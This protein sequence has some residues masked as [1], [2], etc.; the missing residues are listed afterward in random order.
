MRP[1]G[2]PSGKPSGETER[3]RRAVT[4]LLQVAAPMMEK[5][6]RS[7]ADGDPENGV[8]PDPGKAIDLVL[9]AAEYH[10]PKLAR[11]EMV[12]DPDKPMFMVNRIELVGMD[13]NGTDQATS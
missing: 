8:K 5:W 1:P 9:K 10:I 6:L 7:V 13:G 12:G 4:A 2:R 3:A 11:T